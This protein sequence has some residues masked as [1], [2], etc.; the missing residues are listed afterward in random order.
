[1][2]NGTVVIIG[3]GLGGVAAALTLA[4]LGRRVILTEASDWLGGQLTTQAVPPDE[5]R[6]IETH[7]ASPSYAELRRRIRDHYRNE[8]PVTPDARAD[9]FLNPGAGLVSALCHEPR[10]AAIEI[11]RMLSPLIGAGLLTVLRRHVPIRVDA[12]GPIIR[13]VVVRDTDNG[14]EVALR[15]SVFLDATE[16]GDLLEL[17]G[18]DHVVG[19]E[20]RAE[21][22]EL[23]APDVP[24]PLDQQ[25]ISWCAALE[26]RPG[27]DH[28]I[29]RPAGYRAWKSRVAAF[30]PG[31]QLSWTDVE[32][33]SL[34][35]RTRPIFAGDPERASTTRDDDLWHYRR[36]LARRTFGPEWPSG[37]VT[38]VNWPQVDYWESPLVGPGIYEADRGRALAGARD[39]TLSFIHWMQTEAPRADGGTGYPG[40]RLRGDV[41]GTGDGL[42]KEVY[43]RESRRI[44]ALR[45]VTEAHIGR[46]MRGEDAGSEVF[47][48]AVGVGFYR[49]DL[50]PST[51][52]RTYV[53]IDC[54][55]FQIPLGA[56]IPR[57]THNL[58]AANKNIGTTH[59][60]N[61][62]YRLH[63]VEWSIGEAAGALAALCVDL[64]ERPEA[65]WGT[66]SRLADLQSLLSARLGVALAWPDDVR[67]AG[68]PRPIPSVVH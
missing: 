54:Y 65:V 1:M 56:L 11:D 17:G 23:H 15:G 31:S 62:A 67:T 14:A 2:Q 38:L 36:I 18:V 13:A 34:L 63:P 3:G 32:P 33:M 24:D 61:G 35:E 19:A 27:E 20:G 60:T 4:R 68:D 59:I 5:H 47:G 12:D 25:A 39:L 21:T 58:V 30:W 8:Y 57:S 45:T 40:L 53:D 51:S 48:D 49:I 37:E 52:G 41:V 44:R 6:W 42:A 43:V 28:T 16:L 10:V 26:Y 22:G 46:E 66:P 7:P 9:P 29:T 64:G 55:P 50:H